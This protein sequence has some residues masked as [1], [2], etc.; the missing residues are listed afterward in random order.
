[1]RDAKQFI[2]LRKSHGMSERNILLC[3]FAK[4][5]VINRTANASRSPPLDSFKFYET[6]ETFAFAS[7]S[8]ISNEDEDSVGEKFNFRH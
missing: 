8:R 2:R 5:S 1:M 6:R 4:S 7:V 3:V